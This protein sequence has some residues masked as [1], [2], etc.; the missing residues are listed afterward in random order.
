MMTS[1]L[2]CS[3]R[4]GFPISEILLACSS[5]GV[6]FPVREHRQEITTQ[7]L[8]ISYAPQLRLNAPNLKPIVKKNSTLAH[9]FKVW[10][11]S[12]VC[13]QHFKRIYNLAK[14]VVSSAPAAL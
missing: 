4:M 7:A 6:G 13:E 10:R 3:P 8:M 1:S 2:L 5:S 9:A 11:I 12:K 14:K